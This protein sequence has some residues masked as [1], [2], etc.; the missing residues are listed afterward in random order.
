MEYM[1]RQIK[2]RVILSSNEVFYTGNE[3]IKFTY[4]PMGSHKNHKTTQAITKDIGFS[5]QT[6]CKTL[7]LKIATIQF[8]EQRAF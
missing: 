6:D 5:P 4:W 2:L 1:E 8:T 7:L 3:H